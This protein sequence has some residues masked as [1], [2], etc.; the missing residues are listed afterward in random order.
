MRLGRRFW[1]I[2]EQEII[3]LSST[4]RYFDSGEERLFLNAEILKR[5]NS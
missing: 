3:F 4:V 5:W 1:F 2:F